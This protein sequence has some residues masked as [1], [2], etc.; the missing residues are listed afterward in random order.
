MEF[1]RRFFAKHVH[2]HRWYVCVGEGYDDKLFCSGCESFKRNPNFHV[3]VTGE[4]NV[5]T[6]FTASSAGSVEV[7]RLGR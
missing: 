4:E 1:I 5:H 2:E 6:S 7:T 3:S